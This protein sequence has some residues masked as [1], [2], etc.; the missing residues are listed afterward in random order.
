MVAIFTWRCP[1]YGCRGLITTEVE[2]G[3]DELA[4]CRIPSDSPDPYCG[5]EMRWSFLDNEWRPVGPLRGFLRG[6]DPAPQ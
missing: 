1:T 5:R 4:V 2:P 3:H 6:S